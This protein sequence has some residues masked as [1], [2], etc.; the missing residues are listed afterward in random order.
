MNIAIASPRGKERLLYVDYLIDTVEPCN[1][2]PKRSDHQHTSSTKK[3]MAAA[4]LL[5][6]LPEGPAGDTAAAQSFAGNALAKIAIKQTHEPR[7]AMTSD[8]C[9]IGDVRHGNETWQC[10]CA[11]TAHR[12]RAVPAS[13]APDTIAV[14][15]SRRLM[16]MLKTE[17]LNSMCPDGR[18]YNPYANPSD[19][20]GTCSPHL[21]IFRLFPPEAG[22]RGINPADWA[23][24]TQDPLMARE[25]L[26]NIRRWRWDC[27]P[28]T[29]KNPYVVYSPMRLVDCVRRVPES[30]AAE[31]PIV[32]E[33]Y[34]ELAD[35]LMAVAAAPPG[36]KFVVAELGA[37][38][39]PWALRT[40]YA[41]RRLGR[42]REY[43]GIV[44]D[45]LGIHATWTRQ[46]FALNGFDPSQYRIIQGFAFNGAASQPNQNVYRLSKLLKDVDHVD[47]LDIDV[48]GAEKY[49]LQSQQ[50]AAAFE[51]KVVRV[52][53]EAHSV[54][55]GTYVTDMLVK[56]GFR[57]VRNA[58]SN[59]NWMYHAAGIGKVLFR[60]G[61]IAASNTRFENTMG[62]KC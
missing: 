38:Y 58:T 46:H 10:L 15:A 49:I 9:S 54:R 23:N 1:V 27:T 16:N 36:G 21:P 5:Y 37:R 43:Y 11:A 34:F 4:K 29:Y 45:N 41:A 30:G 48:Q 24:I 22:T 55:I 40:M 12:M 51:Q 50:D 39:A 32:D 44:M 7:Q 35:G 17:G 59:M 25:W 3:R 61:Y 52:H 28:T 19:E 33:E 42:S 8:G 57:I 2:G 26:G 56:H 18:V 20:R 13:P 31:L 62:G 6:G 53:I 47:L 14:R 60:S